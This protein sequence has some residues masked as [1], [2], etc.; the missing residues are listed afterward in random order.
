MR[1]TNTRLKPALLAIAALASGRA[2]DEDVGA[3]GVLVALALPDAVKAVE[4]VVVPLAAGTVVAP[5]ERGML[6]A[7]TS[8][9]IGVTET[10]EAGVVEATA[11]DS[12]GQYVVV[13]ISVM[14]VP[15]ETK[16]AVPV[17]VTVIELDVLV[18]FETPVAEANA[19]TAASEV[20][21]AT[22]LEVEGESGV[23]LGRVKVGEFPDPPS[24]MQLCDVRKGHNGIARETYFF[25][26]AA[27][28]LVSLVW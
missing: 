7:V 22:E 25:A 10:V 28:P 19:D 27:S 21:D 24:T 16:V 12:P 4:M 8:V 13:K 3:V 11:V 5:V 14:V 26:Q 6:G 20:L 23:Q 1:P 17:D 15:A 18:A 9:E 2:G